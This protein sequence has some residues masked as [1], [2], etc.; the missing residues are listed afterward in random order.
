MQRVELLETHRAGTIAGVCA[1]GIGFTFA[2]GTWANGE[3]GYA[4]WIGGAWAGM[5]AVGAV[6]WSRR[7]RRH[8]VIEAG[9]VALDGVELPSPRLG[10][11]TFRGE[12]FTT[13]RAFHIASEGREIWL[14][15]WG[16]PDLKATH[17]AVA[18]LLP[19]LATD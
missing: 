16:F 9:H 2:V 14:S 5:A 8:L 19:P 11:L 6:L 13:A 3:P 4:V 18:E 7:H 12:G 17:A 10:P 1:A 15:E